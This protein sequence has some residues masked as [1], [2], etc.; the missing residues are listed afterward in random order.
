VRLT[1]H[2][3]GVRQHR[4]RE[5]DRKGDV[6]TL[7]FVGDTS[8]G[9]AYLD[10]RWPEARNRLE[11]DPYSFFERLDPLISDKFLLIAN[12]ETVLARKP[13]DIFAG[14]KRYLGWDD[15]DRTT[16][17]LKQIGADVVSLANN[18][19]MDFG[20]EPLLETIS[21][22]SGAGIFVI[23]AGANETEAARP[24]SCDLG[25]HN[26]YVLSAFEYRRSYERDFAAY[27]KHD[28]PGVNPLTRGDQPVLA[29]ALRSLRSAD[30][31]SL[32]IVYPHWGGAKNYGWANEKMLGL[33]DSFFAQGADL[34]L[35]HGSHCLQELRFSEAGSTVFS[36]GNF[37]FNSPGRYAKY[38]ALPF[39]LVARLEVGL[40]KSGIWGSLRLYPIFSDNRRTGFRPRPVTES[41]AIPIRD[42]LQARSSTWD[43]SKASIYLDRDERG[44]FVSTRDQL[45]RRI[46]R[47]AHPLADRA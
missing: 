14:R 22:V 30:P 34:V 23:G 6:L 21:W 7:V 33:N 39:S 5:E 29:D 26:L 20:P 16:S 13:V 37:V 2:C 44:W 35:G 43:A 41:E 15:P 17:M 19:S 38:G 18:H 40:D 9:D 31:N 32:V 10:A 11:N 36:L 27:A 47:R 12:L 42:I 25:G 1:S 46:R 8:L 28:R 4:R 3:R 45:S 24:F